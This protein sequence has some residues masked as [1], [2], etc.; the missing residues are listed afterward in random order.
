MALNDHTCLF[1]D[2]NGDMWWFSE[3]T[4]AQGTHYMLIGG[5]GKLVTET[6]DLGISFQSWVQDLIKQAMDVSYT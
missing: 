6:I 1:K 2:F 3:H 4:D 5:D